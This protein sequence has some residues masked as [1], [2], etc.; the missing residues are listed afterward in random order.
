MNEIFALPLV[1]CV[2]VA[3]AILSSII[4]SV[5]H[6]LPKYWYAFKTRISR[7]FTRRPTVDYPI[8]LDSRGLV[9]LEQA[10]IQIE[11]LEVQVNNLTKSQ[12]VRETNR[13]NHIRRVVREYLEEIRTK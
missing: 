2:I 3:T 1:L 8:I 12:V 7:L 9:M 13:K 10:C 6:L 5:L 11:K 4:T